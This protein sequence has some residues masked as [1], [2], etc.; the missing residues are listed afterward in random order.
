MHLLITTIANI[1]KFCVP[2]TLLRALY[3]LSSL[4][5][6]TISGGR[7]LI[8]LTL[9]MKKGEFRDQ[10]TCQGWAEK[11]LC[12]GL[13]L[14]QLTG[15]LMLGS[16]L[17][18]VLKAA[19]EAGRAGAASSPSLQARKGSASL[20]TELTRLHLQAAELLLVGS[21]CG[22]QAAVRAAWFVQRAKAL[23]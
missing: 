8:I 4:I 20:R 12:G 17:G 10:T 21:C 16:L 13:P 7:A 23:G 5:L 11:K 1:Y 15:E 14:R 18:Q 3:Q 9:Q 19:W 2:C 6:R 22:H